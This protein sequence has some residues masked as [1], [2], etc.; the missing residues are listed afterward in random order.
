[1]KIRKI[2]YLM[3]VEKSKKYG[4]DT[5]PPNNQYH[6]K[7]NFNTYSVTSEGNIKEKKKKK[8][9]LTNCAKYEQVK[10]VVP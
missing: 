3:K 1:M 5:T 10:S 6:I 9:F 7:I 8:S 4:D 2:L